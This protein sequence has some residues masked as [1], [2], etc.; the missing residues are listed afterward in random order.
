[1]TTE[2][3]APTRPLLFPVSCRSPKGVRARAGAL[4]DWLSGPGTG[5]DLADVAHTL[6]RRRP[7]LPVRAAVLAHDRHELADRLRTLATGESGEGIVG[8]D[9]PR[10]VPSDAVFVFSGYGS[11]W[12]G[13]GSGLLEEPAFRAVLDELEPVFRAEGRDAPRE[14]VTRAELSR[15]EASSIQPALFAMQVGLAAVWQHYGIRPAAVLGQ[16]MGE[17]AAAVVS[18]GLPL[19]DAAHVILRRSEV[20]RRRMFGLGATAVV[21][22]P[23]PEVERRL[24]AGFD[25]EIAVHSSTRA[26]VVAG[27]VNVMEAFLSSC[28][29]DGIATYPVRGGDAAGHSRF[30]DRV[31][32]ELTGLLSDIGGKTPTVRFYSTTLSD[33]RATPAFDGAYW[34]ANVRRPV[35]FLDAVRAA[36]ADGL[37]TFVEVSPHPVAV[38]SLADILTDTEVGDGVAWETLRR[39]EPAGSAVLVGLARAHCRGLDVD[40][41]RLYPSGRLVDLPTTVWDHGQRQP[42]TGRVTV[43][44]EDTHPLLGVHVQ[45]PGTPARHVWQTTLDTSRLTWLDDHRLGELPLLP[46]TGYCEMALSAACTAFEAKPEDVVLSDIEFRRLLPLAAPTTVTTSVTVTGTGEAELEIGSRQGGTDVVHATAKATVR[47]REPA[48]ADTLDLNGLLGPSLAPAEIYP[49]LRDAGLNHGPVFAG[50]TGVSITDGLATGHVTRPASVR[51]DPRMAFHPALLDACLHGIATAL[52]R[53]TGRLCLPAGISGLRLIGEL[54]DNLVCRSRVQVQV[55]GCTA[56]LEVYDEDGLLVAELRGV[57]FRHLDEDALPVSTDGLLHTL[58]YEP[59]PLPAEDGPAASGDWLVYGGGA[60]DEFRA[61]LL[62]H[63]ERAGIR[64]TAL[65]DTKAALPAAQGVVLLAWD[66]DQ[67]DADALTGT[68]QRLLSW[69]RLAARLADGTGTAVPPRFYAVT[70]GACLPGDDTTVDLAQAGLTGLT[71]SLRAERPELRPTLVDLDPAPDPADLMR[72]LCSGSADDEV[73]WRAG[74]RQVARLTPVPADRPAVPERGGLVRSDGGYVVT[75]G[76]GGLG[77]ATARLLAEGGAGCVVLNGR[78]LPEPDTARA[79][80]EIRAT[81]TRVALVLGDIAAP[82]VADRLMEAVT[83]MGAAVRG[84]VHA[85]GVLDDALVTDLDAE[86]IGRAWSAKAVGAWRLHLATPRDGVDW[87]IGYSSSA[88]LLGAPGQ[89]NYAAANACLDAVAWWRRARGLPGLSVNWGPW[90]EIGGARDAQVGGLGKIRPREAFAALE[91]LLARESTQ[92]GVVR[93]GPDYPV[94]FPETRRSSYFARVVAGLTRDLADTARF[95]RHRL[96]GMSHEAVHRAVTERLI[97]RIR[98]LLR[99]QGAGLPLTT[100]LVHLG[101]DSLAAQRIKNAVRDD[102]RIDVPVSRLLQ[103]VSVTELADEITA[104]LTDT[105]GTSAEPAEERAEL[106]SR[107]RRTRMAQQQA[108][109]R[110][111]Q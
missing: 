66:T 94:V 38:R 27:D 17:L 46:G 25:L 21:E 86:R 109:R 24:R 10:Q 48:A 9:E 55:H 69:F 43:A 15:A 99:H 13:M 78:S 111:P 68:E 89:A 59:A 23:V 62:S 56:D 80:E 26:T 3:T 91:E 98:P 37:R 54:S 72:E 40:W 108:R 100:P 67:A 58:E 41:G 73:L 4:A 1:M 106:R 104:G 52:V 7:R 57:L 8:P 81:G 95:E 70:R 101:L 20:M 97:E 34:A 49:R 5:A 87:W 47:T 53:D 79:I 105:Q 28:E 36:T 22:L 32:P 51:P 19:T 18:G 96:R 63:M 6:A 44:A 75:G 88:A 11:Q 65:A 61:R 30:A 50:L 76:T 83:G 92:A 77:L 35:R 45:L 102:F 90:A 85:A 64:P 84:V 42:V 110:R 33:P 14:L 107:T 82:E 12:D 93:L 2:L 71:R 39:G 103:G 29:A 16:S 74:V 60:E 31:V